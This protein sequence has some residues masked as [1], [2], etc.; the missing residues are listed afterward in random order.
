[1]VLESWNF[2][3]NSIT[4]EHLSNLSKM[5]MELKYLSMEINIEENIVK[6]N[7]MVKE[8]IHGSI[9]LFLKEIS[10][11]VWDM[12]MEHGNQPK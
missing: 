9:L 12:D 4:K 5:D 6:A 1:M 3:L 8:N 2:H 11:K 10:T 7:S